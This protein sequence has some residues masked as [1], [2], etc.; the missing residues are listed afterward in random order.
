MLENVLVRDFL[1]LGAG[2]KPQIAKRRCLSC[3]SEGDS[4]PLVAMPFGCSPEGVLDLAE[5]RFSP[6]GGAPIGAGD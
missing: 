5:G 1:L 3:L 2:A 6:Q 4:L